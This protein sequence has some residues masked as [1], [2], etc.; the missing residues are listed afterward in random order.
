[1]KTTHTYAILEISAGAYAEIR[2]LLDAAGYQHAFHDD[3]VDMHGIAVRA[4]AD[5]RSLTSIMTRE[6]AIEIA[7][8]SREGA[9]IVKSST[10][11]IV[12]VEVP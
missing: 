6:R 8:L 3:V 11:A 12:A 10:G 4:K 2:A 5:E 1:M 7:R 9:K